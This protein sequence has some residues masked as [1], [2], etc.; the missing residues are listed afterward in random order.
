M[1]Q[2][3]RLLG[4]RCGATM[5]MTL[6]A[7]F[8]A[9]ERYERGLAERLLRRVDALPDVRLW[10]IADPERLAERTPTLA[11]THARCSPRE[12]AERLGREGRHKVVDKFDIDPLQRQMSPPHFARKSRTPQL[13][14]LLLRHENPIH[15]VRF[16]FAFNF[17]CL[18][19]Y[20][21]EV[22]FEEFAQFILG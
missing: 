17:Y 12:V 18:Q 14:D 15:E 4:Q 11:V 21:M 6:L 10:G 19:R 16:S 3:L 20:D 5:Y 7:G 8:G 9:I 2:R 22:A 1:T 13:A